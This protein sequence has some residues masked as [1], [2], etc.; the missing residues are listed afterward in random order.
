MPKGTGQR[1]H[2]TKGDA[3]L[4]RKAT[5]HQD[6]VGQAEPDREQSREVEKRRIQRDREQLEKEVVKETAQELERASAVAEPARAAQGGQAGAG[7]ER[8]QFA[9]PG[10]LREGIDLIRRRGPPALDA[11]RAKAEQ[12]LGEMPS[13]VRTAVHLT[14]R[15]IG[16]ALWPVRAGARLVGHV[17]ETPAALLRILIGRRSA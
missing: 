12:R 4:S 2:K 16:L 3:A 17:L 11:L 13:P 9:I 7:Q 6:F 14:E 1:G 15:A 5:Q 10:S 8:P